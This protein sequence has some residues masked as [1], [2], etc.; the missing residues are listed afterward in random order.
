[1]PTTRENLS[2][3]FLACAVKFRLVYVA[4]EKEVELLHPEGGNG[5]G[6]IRKALNGALL[7]MLQ[8]C[9]NLYSRTCK[10]QTARQ[11]LTYDELP[12][13]VLRYGFP[14]SPSAE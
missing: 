13:C 11:Q 2:S 1:M 10:C 3:T 4:V 12:D 9:R 14:A 8:G 7:S 6:Q 5:A